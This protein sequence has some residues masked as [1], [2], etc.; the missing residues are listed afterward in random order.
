MMHFLPNWSACRQTPTLEGYLLDQLE[1]EV[2]KRNNKNRKYNH[3]ENLIILCQMLLFF[4]IYI[5]L[6]FI[7][8]YLFR[9][10]KITEYE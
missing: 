9:G 4:S 5:L 8:R 10:D 6:K 7:C 3:Q 1:M 2:L